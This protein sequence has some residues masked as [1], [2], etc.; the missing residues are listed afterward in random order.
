MNSPLLSQNVLFR[1][2][3]NP[4]GF[5]YWLSAFPYVSLGPPPVSII[6]VQCLMLTICR[7]PNW[8]TM[9]NLLFSK[10]GYIMDDFAVREKLNMPLWSEC[11]R[12]F[13]STGFNLPLVQKKWEYGTQFSRLVQLIRLELL[14]LGVINV[15]LR[16]WSHEQSL[17][18]P[19]AYKEEERY[20]SA[21]ISEQIKKTMFCSPARVEIRSL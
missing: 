8:A 15:D 7:S 18:C 11:S 19:I 14:L 4:K 12:E 17:D 13:S 20:Q 16:N 5:L 6:L 21:A 1:R 10:V 3:I 9:T 2:V